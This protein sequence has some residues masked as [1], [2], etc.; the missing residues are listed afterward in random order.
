[1]NLGIGKEGTKHRYLTQR[2]KKTQKKCVTGAQTEKCTMEPSQ[3]DPSYNG[4]KREG[5]LGLE[6]ITRVG[7][8]TSIVE[9]SG[10][11]VPGTIDLHRA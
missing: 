11:K 1:M 5:K 9:V 7:N 2:S 4:T 10:Q 8:G 6:L 3:G